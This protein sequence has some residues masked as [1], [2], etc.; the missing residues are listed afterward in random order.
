MSWKTTTFATAAYLMC[1][2]GS[3]QAQPTTITLNEAVRQGKVKVHV[4]QSLSR[5][6]GPNVRVEVEKL[7]PEA[8]HVEVE[9]GTVLL[10]VDSSEQNL[11]VGM[12]KGEFIAANKY[13]PGKVMVLADNTKR[14]FL[15]EVYCLDY[16]KKAPQKGRGLQLAL[17]DKRAARILVPPPGLEPSL[18]AVQIAIWMD[19]AGIS[20]EE[21]RK[22]FRGETTDKDVDDA[23]KLLLH[24][25]QAGVATIPEGIST[26][27]RVEIGRLFS[28]DPAVRVEAAGVLGKMGAAALPAIPFI[29]DNVLDMSSDRPLPASVATVDVNVV[30]DAANDV[31]GKLNMPELKPL[32]DLARGPGLGA[33]LLP[34]GKM[35]IKVPQIVGDILADRAILGLKQ[36]SPALRLGA[37]K[38]LGARGDRRA[39]EPLIEILGD[40][41]EQVREAAAEALKSITGQDFGGDA[42]KWKDWLKNSQ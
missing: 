18:A 12:L 19:R 38:T 14:S 30:I 6:A 23:K 3:L 37:V 7:V 29:A 10:N 40:D 41:N 21:A 26:E 1:A 39:V 4:Q 13:R 35:E 42:A 17:L 9:V 22:R 20:A 25:E 5:A 28:P 16:A 24:A 34:G 11:A 8:L 15:L 27:V 2:C 32:I 36:K 31:L 33:D